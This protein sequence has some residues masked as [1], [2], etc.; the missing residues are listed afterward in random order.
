MLLAIFRWQLDLICIVSGARHRDSCRNFPQ[1]KVIKVK[2]LVI[3]VG[4]LLVGFTLT[5]YQFNVLQG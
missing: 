1:P 2:L 3:F 5:G 4:I